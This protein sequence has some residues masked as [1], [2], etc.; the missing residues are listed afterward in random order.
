ME[1]GLLYEEIERSGWRG[2]HGTQMKSKAG[3]QDGLNGT[4]S[5]G[6]NALPAGFH[7]LEEGFGG[8]GNSTGF[9]TS[10]GGDLSGIVGGWTVGRDSAVW[11]RWLG[12]PLESVNRQPDKVTST[13][14]SACR[15]VK[16]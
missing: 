8:L 7:Q 5:S 10:P 3:W 15:C 2:V 12:A 4:N 1:L 13:F 16:D 9:W 6:F 14:G 11:Q